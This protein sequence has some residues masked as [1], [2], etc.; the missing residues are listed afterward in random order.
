[1]IVY[2]KVSRVNTKLTFIFCLLLGISG[3]SRTDPFTSTFLLKDTWQ[4]QE[5]VAP[6]FPFPEEEETNPV[7]IAFPKTEEYTV[8]L[9]SKNCSGTYIAKQNGEIE[10]KRTTCS[11]SSSDSQWDHYFITLMQ[12]STRFTAK[13]KSS[14]TLFINEDNYLA[15]KYQGDSQ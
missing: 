12:K 8:F 10:F 13:E 9:K 14:L 2:N 15:F 11:F 1:M 5:V 6:D 7:S 3:C 4:L